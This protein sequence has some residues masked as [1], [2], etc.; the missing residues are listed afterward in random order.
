MAF[1][2]RYEFQYYNWLGELCLIEIHNESGAASTEIEAMGGDPVVID[3]GNQGGDLF[4]PI[5]GSSATFTLMTS[6]TQTW[7]EFFGATSRDYKVYFKKDGVTFWAGWLIPE[8]CQDRDIGHPHEFEITAT[9]GLADLQKYKFVD[10]SGDRILTN[11]QVIEILG[12]CLKKINLLGSTGAYSSVV[13]INSALN[14]YDTAF[15]NYTSGEQYDPL[16]Q[17]YIDCRYFLD[18]DYNPKDCY[19]V[20]EQILK[21]FGAR[22]FAHGGEYWI[23][24][25]ADNIQEYHYRKF[26][27][28]G[29][30][31]I[32]TVASYTTHNPVKALT[33]ST[34][35]N[36]NIA[37]FINQSKV[38]GQITPLKELT[39]KHN[40]GYL[41][42]RIIPYHDFP[43]WLIISV[44]W[45]LRLGDV[46]SQ[47]TYSYLVTNPNYLVYT[48]RDENHIWPGLKTYSGIFEHELMSPPVYIYDAASGTPNPTMN[49]QFKFRLVGTSGG[50]ASVRVKI[51]I[52]AATDRY[53]T[54]TA[55]WTTSDTYISWTGL[56]VNEGWITR[57]VAVD[58]WPV[59]GT[60]YVYMG[61]AYVTSGSVSYIEFE[62]VKFNM[63]PGGENHYYTGSNITY[64]LN[65]EYSDTAEVEFDMGDLPDLGGQNEKTVYRGFYQ[66]S[67]SQSAD[68][69]TTD[70]THRY[71]GA[72]GRLID[73]I[74]AHYQAMY[75]TNRLFIEGEL[76]GDIDFRTCLQDGNNSNKLFLPTGLTYHDKDNV[77]IG[78]WAEAFGHDVEIDAELDTITPVD[79]TVASVSPFMKIQTTGG[80]DMYTSAP[81]YEAQIINFNIVTDPQTIGWSLSVDSSPSWI[82]CTGTGTGDTAE[83]Y[84]VL[85]NDTGSPRSATIRLEETT[86]LGVNDWTVLVT[87]QANP[88]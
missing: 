67:S 77:W 41:G 57:E 53:L 63:T 66:T 11:K 86:S 75:G 23:V 14:I 39:I 24:P 56:T 30:S 73:I 45:P 18:D 81:D 25:I 78:H 69:P 82:T 87:Q 21:S 60:L 12:I 8:L 84:S 15:T 16:S 88:I 68:N 29:A 20:L 28:D 51:K 52:D 42:D 85:E 65:S 64:T 48:I 26:V 38:R 44:S 22:I 76:L 4:D 58:T 54:K 35:T 36:S 1:A 34:A 55:G 19:T 80:V 43:S 49:F 7:S 17:A 13:I 62:H 83:S 5:V 74:S 46:L 33:N 2:K 3:Y 32:D 47:W 31:N 71:T 9:D 72:N 40:Y 50:T 6:A 37:C 70:W 59:A 10:S 79:L 27:Y 61:D